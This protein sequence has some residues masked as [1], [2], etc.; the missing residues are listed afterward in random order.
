MLRGIGAKSSISYLLK[1]PDEIGI[2]EIQF[3][4]DLPL[5]K[6]KANVELAKPYVAQVLIELQ[7]SADSY[8][9]FRTLLGLLK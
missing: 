3:D 4:T 6:L 8:S 7:K 9:V 5:D 1:N 2:L